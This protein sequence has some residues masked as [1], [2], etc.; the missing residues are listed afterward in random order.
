MKRVL[1]ILAVAIA[2]ASCENGLTSDTER[3]TQYVLDAPD[4]ILGI[5]QYVHDTIEQVITKEV[6]FAGEVIADGYGDCLDLSHLMLWLMDKKGIEGG[7]LIALQLP[8]G[9]H[10]VIWHEGTYYDPTNYRF[11][12]K[13]WPEEWILGEF[14]LFEI[15]Y[16]AIWY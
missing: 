15:W 5:R 14:T 3:Q 1:L 7:K 8:E 2:F 9:K 13:K 16:T 12:D 11:E 10:G 6:R 4:D